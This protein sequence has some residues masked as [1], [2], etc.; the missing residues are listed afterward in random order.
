MAVCDFDPC[1][2]IWGRYKSK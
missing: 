2:D 1:L